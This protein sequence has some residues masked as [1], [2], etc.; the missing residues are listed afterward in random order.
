MAKSKIKWTNFEKAQLDDI[1]RFIREIEQ[2]K[3]TPNFVDFFM[4]CL[5]TENVESVNL[6]ALYPSLYKTLNDFLKD[7]NNK[8]MT[9]LIRNISKGIKK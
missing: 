7:F 5:V 1:D 2:D 6:K 9:L 8:T 4:L 3:N